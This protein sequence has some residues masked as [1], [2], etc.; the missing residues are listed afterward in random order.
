MFEDIVHLLIS[1]PTFFLFILPV[2]DLSEQ[3]VL[4]ARGGHLPAATA[5]EVEPERLHRAL[6]AIF[7]ARHQTCGRDGPSLLVRIN[8]Q[9]IIATTG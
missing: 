7:R 3:H 9:H 8:S 4:E 5:V 2:L 6:E 1:F